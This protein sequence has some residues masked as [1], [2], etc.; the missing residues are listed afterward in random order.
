ME[1]KII[2]QEDNFDKAR[3]LHVPIP[4]EG[5]QIDFPPA[6]ELETELMWFVKKKYL[7]HK[8]HQP[9]F[10]HLLS[11]KGLENIYDFLSTK[12]HPTPITQIINKYSGV[13][14]L[15]KIRENYA[16]DGQC[17]RSIDMFMG[18]YAR[19][20][21]NLAFMSCC[22]SGLFFIGRLALKYKEH[23]LTPNFIA[24]F[25]KHDRM[26]ELLRNI[27]L[28]LITNPDLPLL[29]CANVAQNFRDI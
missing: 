17:R 12:Y 16:R 8:N 29:G 1:G 10:E 21:K 2:I 24:E 7:L 22:Y 14:K 27:P 11:G 19:A 6:N 26:P 15:D 20:A 13:E 28:Y 3:K 23:F 5:G 9:D 4:S 25:L 18:F